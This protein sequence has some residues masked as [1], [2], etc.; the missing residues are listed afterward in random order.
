M[1]KS[2]CCKYKKQYVYINGVILPFYFVLKR[3]HQK[4]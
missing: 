4:I 3:I 2:L 1:Y